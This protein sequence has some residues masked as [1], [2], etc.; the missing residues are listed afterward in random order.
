MLVME[1]NKKN[2]AAEKATEQKK[3]SYDELNKIAS[4]LHLSNQKLYARV[5]ELQEMLSNRDFE[6]SSFFLNALFRVVDHAEM[7]D[8]D[9][10]NWCIDNIK[11]A[12]HSFVENAN[13]ADAKKDGEAE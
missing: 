5:Q 9:F 13:P 2:V 10:A 4:D 12:M 1:E 8:A 3:L 6:Y 11:S 7:Y